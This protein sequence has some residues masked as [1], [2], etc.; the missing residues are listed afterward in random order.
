M[1]DSKLYR[2]A[3]PIVKIFT[4]T[5]LRPKYEGLSNI[6]SDK[7]VI[8]AGTHTN[9]LDCLVLMSST[10]R[11]IH[12][13]AKDEL[14][15]GPKKI[16]FANM[17]LIPVNRKTKDHNAIVQAE[18]YLNNNSVIGIFPEGTTEKGRGLLPFKKGAVKMAKDTNTNIVP[19]II[20]GKYRLFSNNLKI[21]FGEPIKI[22][23]SDLDIENDKLRTIIQDM[24]GEEWDVYI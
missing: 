5:F 14:W 3:R 10:K 18:K 22:S 1:T 19:F 13:L 15:H 23:N 2:F 7:S 4:N 21:T 17:G 20:T 11:S 9:I 16:I 12:F 6:P 24:L 8:L